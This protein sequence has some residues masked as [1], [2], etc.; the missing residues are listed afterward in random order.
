MRKQIETE[1]EINASADRVWKILSDFPAYST[2]NPFVREI[3]GAPKVGERLRVF[4]QLP[5]GKGMTFKPTVLKA[6][7][8]RELR[9]LGRLI[10]PGIFDGEHYFQIEPIGE[11]RIRFMHGEKFRGLL[12]R[13]FAGTLEKGTTEGFKAMNEALKK[14]AEA[15]N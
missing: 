2:W 8:N 15:V 4:V 1:I 12:V 11:D 9:W 10:I 14:R 7:E 3:S 6:E 5:G 13:L